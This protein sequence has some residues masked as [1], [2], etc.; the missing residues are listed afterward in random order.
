MFRYS[1]KKLIALSVLIPAAVMLICYYKKDIF[2][3]GDNSVLIIDSLHQY[4]PFIAE[5]REKLVSGESLLYSMNGGFGYNLWA[6]IAYYAASPLNLLS[7]FVPRENV[8]DFMAYLV[9]VKTCIASTC[10][11]CYLDSKSSDKNYVPVIFGCMYAFSAYMIGYYFNIMWLDSIMVFPLVMKGIENLLEKKSGK[12]YGISL[13][14][15]IYCNYYIGFMICLFSCLYFLSQWTVKKLEKTGTGFSDFLRFGWFSLLSGGMG[16]F[17]LIPAYLALS[18]TEGSGTGFPETIKC[19]VDWIEQWTG[20]FA[21]TEPFHVHGSDGG[22]NLY[23]GC[24]IMILVLIYLFDKKISFIRRMANTGLL[25]L[26]LVSMNCNILSFIWHGFHQQINLPNRFAF[27]YIALILVM[28]FETF[29]H[30]REQNWAVL[31]A[32][33]V[34]P[35]IFVCYA[36]LNKTGGHSVY[37]Y[38]ITLVLLVIY[39]ALVLF[40]K[41]SGM[42]KRY[43]AVATVLICVVM[44]GE[45]V[46]Y[47][48]YGYVKKTN[49]ITRSYYLDDLAAYEELEAELPEGNYRVEADQQNMRNTNTFWGQKG[50]SLFSSTMSAGITEFCERIGMEAGYNVVKY[51]AFTRLFN[52]IFGVRYV[53]SREGGDSLYQM[54]KI[55]EAGTLSLYENE[56]ALSVGFM[57]SENIKDW[58]I[59]E[60]GS[61]TQTQQSFVKYATGLD[62]EYTLRNVYAFEEGPLYVIEL[63]P[64]EQ[65]YVE[66]ERSTK[67]VTIKTPQYEKTYTYGTRFLF[68]LGKVD[69]INKANVSLKYSEGNTGGIITR[70]YTLADETY[71]TVYEKLSSNQMNVTVQDENLIKGSIDVKES[72]TLFLTVPCDTGW[73]VLV[74]GKETEIYSVGNAFMGIDLEEGYHE[75]SM[76]YVPDGFFAGVLISVA[77]AVLFLLSWIFESRKK[78]EKKLFRR[79]TAAFPA[80]EVRTEEIKMEIA[81]ESPEIQKERA[82]KV[83]EFGPDVIRVLAVCLVLAV[84]FFLRN[85]FASQPVNSF[86]MVSAVAVRS[87]CLTCIPQFLMLTGYLKCGKTW[88]KRYYAPLV[89]VMV[90]WVLVSVVSLGFHLYQDAGTKTGY[91]WL[92]KFFDFTLADYSWYINMYFG[93]FLLTPFM[94]LLWNSLETKKMHTFFIMVL[95][96]VTFLP[97]TLNSIA[98]DGETKL[99]ILPYY[100][101]GFWPF[102]YYY[103]GC[104]IATYRP[105]IKLKAGLPVVT[106]VSALMAVLNAVTG[107][108]E[109]YFAGYTTG[110]SHLAIAFM[111]TVVF[112]SLYHIE[113][114]SRQ[115]SYSVRRIAA[116]VLETY[117]IS[118]IFDV[119]IYQ[120]N[121]GVF[122][123]A[124]YLPQGIVRFALVFACSVSAGWI[125]HILS[126]RISKKLTDRWAGSGFSVKKALILLGVIIGSSILLC[127]NDH[128]NMSGNQ[129]IPQTENT[130]SINIEFDE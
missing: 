58:N 73:K 20:H 122:E 39:E 68:N 107:G 22:A 38:I 21:F 118:Y 46:S 47:A 48:Y 31:A 100:W 4:L 33:G 126:E 111:G 116:V 53:T 9:I 26:L 80:G 76:K 72:G 106:A 115:L 105:K 127:W 24:I 86:W 125:I 36:W 25:V 57:V 56:D 8:M 51:S 42:N 29:T 19:Y 61:F 91:Q 60:A 82:E 40:L 3:F 6:A 30:I 43:R 32:A 103:L 74:D 41:K 7:V 10:L 59:K 93:I 70:I 88:K 66:F 90:S 84:H 75:I 37:S 110:Y 77:S 112:L 114:E 23:C 101:S 63:H 108:A 15:T 129:T 54:D 5:L 27:I 83:Y 97:S 120:S 119:I 121:T 87:I 11:S 50:I 94:N 78:H 99:N 16:A 62:F 69:S 45:T 92:T 104:Y 44:L 35:V 89:K 52:D 64:G 13:F 130:G 12:L 18:K 65:T 128:G 49:Q 123:P 96:L 102:A 95:C 124:H 79:K 109:N 67:E 113:C 34:L 98:F 2:P 71:E 28:G 117:L 1:K 85:G 14:W 55:A 17:M 81:E